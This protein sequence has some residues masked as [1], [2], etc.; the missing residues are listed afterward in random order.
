MRDEKFKN[1]EDKLSK[2]LLKLEDKEYIELI[3]ANESLKKYDNILGKIDNGDYPRDYINQITDNEL[4]EILEYL[5][6]IATK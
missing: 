5:N 6:N 1:I 3:M 2:L 4:N